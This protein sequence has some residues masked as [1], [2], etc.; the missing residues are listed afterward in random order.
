M[1]YKMLGTTSTL[2]AKAW[3]PS[4]IFESWDKSK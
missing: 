3:T 2:A 4:E 1:C